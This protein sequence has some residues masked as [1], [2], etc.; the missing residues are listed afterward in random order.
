MYVASLFFPETLHMWFGGWNWNTTCSCNLSNSDSFIS[1]FSGCSG[2]DRGVRRNC[3][4]FMWVCH[5]YES[6]LSQLQSIPRDS[7][8]CFVFNCKVNLCVPPYRQSCSQSQ[9]RSKFRIQILKFIHLSFEVICEVFRRVSVALIPFMVQLFLRYH[10]YPRHR[11]HVIEHLGTK[12]I[13][14]PKWRLRDLNQNCGLVESQIKDIYIFFDWILPAH[15]IETNSSYF[16]GNPK[17][18]KQLNSSSEGNIKP[19]HIS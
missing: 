5:S 2:A 13:F 6:V 15:Q 1:L 11:V 10:D 8:N 4:S 12:R 7:T 18:S 9:N 17:K 19:R 14:F 16:H 3:P